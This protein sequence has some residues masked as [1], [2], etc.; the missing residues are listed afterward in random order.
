M[1]NMIL[2]DIETGSAAPDSGIFQVAALVVEDGVIIDKHYFFEI[3][4]ETMTAFGFGA[5]YAKISDHIKMKQTFLELLDDYP[6]PVISFNAS[7]DRATLLHDGWLDEGRECFSAQAAI[8][9]THPHLFSYT[10][11]YLSHY[12]KVGLPV[13]HKAYLNSLLLLEVISGASPLE[14]NPV[15]LAKPERDRRIFEGKSIV[16]TG[17]SSQPRVSMSKAA[18]SFG[19][20]VSNTITSKTDFLIVGKRPGSKLERARYLGVPIMSDE[21][22]LET[23]STEPAK[24][25]S[26]YNK[27][28]DVVG[29]MVYLAPMPA[30]YKRK[31]KNILDTMDVSW[32]RDSEDLKPEI[33]IHRD[34]SRSMEGLEMTLSLS[35]FNR[36]LL[37]E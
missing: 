26:P 16:F 9:H 12:F 10:L 13:D 14:W 6:Y 30:P 24:E 35:E 22:F 33:V 21:W 25:A 4:D 36:M 23:I 31:V 20:T 19:A 28:E 15:H 3:K 18:R 2:I 11:S 1:K 5:G 7:L 17:A 27:L 34:G 37:G 8:K 32:V 29:K